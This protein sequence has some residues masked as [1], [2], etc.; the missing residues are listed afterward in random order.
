MSREKGSD[1][2]LSSFSEAVR[3]QNERREAERLE[4]QAK[5]G[6]LANTHWNTEKRAWEYVG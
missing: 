4:W 6:E 3:E 1:W 5:L 2:S